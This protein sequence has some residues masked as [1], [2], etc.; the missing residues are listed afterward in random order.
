[1]FSGWLQPSTITQPAKQRRDDN[2]F[3]WSSQQTFS[4]TGTPTQFGWTVQELNL[5]KAPSQV[6]K[7]VIAWTP[8]A[9]FS[10]TGTPTQFGWQQSF[11]TPKTK[12]PA[13]EL[14]TR[15]AWST[16]QTFSLTGT[17]TQ[18]GFVNPD[19][20]KFARPN[21]RVTLDSAFAIGTQITPATFGWYGQFD[22]PKA[23]VQTGKNS[24]AWTPQATFSLTGTPTQL[25]FLS[26]DSARQPQANNLADLKNVIA[27]PVYPYAAVAQ[28]LFSGWMVAAQQQPQ[29]LNN[30][31]K[32]VFA[33]LPQTITSLASTPAQF[34]WQQAFD[35]PKTKLPAQELVTRSAWTA[36]QT[37]SLTGTSAQFGFYNQFELLKAALS[38]ITA[39]DA[40]THVAAQTEYPITDPYIGWPVQ[41]LNFAKAPSQVDKN[42][43]AWVPQQ[44]FS[45][46]GTPTQFG[47]QQSF[48]AL[49]AQP[50]RKTENNFQFGFTTQAPILGWFTGFSSTPP[51]KVS[52]DLRNTIAYA[53]NQPAV[54]QTLFSGWMTTNQPAAKPVRT[55]EAFNTTVWAPQT[56]PAATPTQLG[57]QQQFAAIPAKPTARVV[58]NFVLGQPQFIPSLG[59]YIAFDQP[60][61]VA[62]KP[63]NDTTISMSFKITG[64]SR[65]WGWIS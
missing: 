55:Q 64:K 35:T 8:Q 3:A 50:A 58:D 38:S 16:Q 60:R 29:A 33:W 59:W 12:L 51:A 39:H 37:F 53:V 56:L 49:V 10:L 32:S 44:T 48:S 47:W 5:A 65:S 15:A 19:S 18:L 17:P 54:V 61:P 30:T 7:N 62:K 46:T 21:N 13:Q 2:N 41:E 57:W 11:D 1:M 31:D 22:L 6:D 25:G 26:P 24:S 28:T 9:T 14:V 40:P 43:I 45:L 63:P 42:V 23:P 4:L 34:G 20:A 52:P 36:Q 27:G